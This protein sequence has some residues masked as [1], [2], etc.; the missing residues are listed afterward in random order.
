MALAL[1]GRA[2]LQSIPAREYSRL[3]DSLAV[4]PKVRRDA[5][6]LRR[7]A[8]HFWSQA[9]SLTQELY[10]CEAA[11]GQLR[12]ALSTEID[13]T[14]RGDAEIDRLKRRLRKRGITNG[15]YTR[16]K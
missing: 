8:R 4:L 9:D 2:Q 7:S 15:P 11:N 3:R 13:L 16:P 6:A 10:Q 1:P 5:A 12:R 14:Q